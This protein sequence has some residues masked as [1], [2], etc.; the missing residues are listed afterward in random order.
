MI[1]KDS[2][3]FEQKEKKVG[4]LILDEAEFTTIKH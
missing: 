2:G 4:A 3:K 1:G